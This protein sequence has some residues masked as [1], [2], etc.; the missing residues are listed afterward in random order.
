M[1]DTV[2]ASW[3]RGGWR[4]WRG[5]GR[6]LHEDIFT[7]CVFLVAGSVPVFSDR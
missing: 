5:L 1:G 7:L 3:L 4:W 6:Q 2:L